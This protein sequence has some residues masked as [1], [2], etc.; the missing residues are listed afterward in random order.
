MDFI[1]VPFNQD[2]RRLWVQGGLF[3]QALYVPRR[4]ETPAK[5]SERAAAAVIRLAP[6]EK[7]AWFM[8]TDGSTG[9]PMADWS[10][11][12]WVFRKSA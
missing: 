8:V 6:K 3:L 11:G 10:S 12:A 1:T 2:G 7:W 9:T 5:C 4:N